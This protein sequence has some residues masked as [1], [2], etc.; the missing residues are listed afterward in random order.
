MY[1]TCV[2]SQVILPIKCSLEVS[3]R[4][5]IQSV[6]EGEGKKIENYF[7]LNFAICNFSLI[8]KGDLNVHYWNFG[9]LEFYSDFEGL[10]SFIVYL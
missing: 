5:S 10:R 6:L 1:I 7:I 9:I 4:N 3:F 8:F 2:L